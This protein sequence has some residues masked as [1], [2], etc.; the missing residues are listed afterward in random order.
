M[1]P[2]SVAVLALAMSTDA[3]AAAVGSAFL[4]ANIVPIAFAIGCTTF[5][6]V[7]AGVMLGRALGAAAGQRAEIAGGVLR[8]GVGA[9]ILHEHL[10]AG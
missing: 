5:V 3:F 9:L 8:V 6:T 4:D 7:T 1:N 10:G 2:A